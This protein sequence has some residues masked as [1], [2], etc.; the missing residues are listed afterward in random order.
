MIHRT[1]RGDMNALPDYQDALDYALHCAKALRRSECVPIDEAGGRILAEAICADRDLPPFNRSAMDGYALR[2]AD[3][4]A[5]AALPCCG[6]IAAGQ[7]GDCVVAPGNCIAIATGAPVPEELDIVIPHEQTDRG[8]RDGRPVEFEATDRATGYAIHPR[9]ADARA[10]DT[11]VPSGTCIEA[12][13][14]GLAAAVG[15][16]TLQ[17]ACKPRVVLLTSGDEVVA[18]EAQPAAHQIRN[19]NGP[20]LRSLA[21]RMGAQVIAHHHLDDEPDS[22]RAALDDAMQQADVVVT[23]GGISAG[24]RDFIPDQLAALGVAPLVS[25]AAIQPGKP[26]RIGHDG[27]GTF[28]VSLPGNPVSVLATACLFL[29]PLLHRLTGETGGL[30]W[31]TVTLASPVRPNPKR[32]QFRPATVDA[33]GLATVP[34]WSGSGDLVHA[35]MTNGLLALPRQEDPVPE[36][37]RLEFLQWPR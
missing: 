15:C 34:S 10:G 36:G 30:P 19:S 3:L 13:H 20:M 37:T 4:A 2:H 11:L 5:G 14:I 35:S 27:D 7:P 25:G 9:G 8:D 21:V 31:R 16:T 18:A 22:V 28:V 23:V 17:V 1:I 33:T 12:D 6:Q 24:D 29:W 32:S 26:V